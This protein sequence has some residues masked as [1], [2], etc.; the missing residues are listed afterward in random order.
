MWYAKLGRENVEKVSFNI[1]S[2]GGTLPNELLIPHPAV[3]WVLVVSCPNT[4][5]VNLFS[6]EPHRVIT[7]TS[8]L[9]KQ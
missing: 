5:L 7:L 9:R 8:T 2:A 6:S 3:F 1:N 4:V